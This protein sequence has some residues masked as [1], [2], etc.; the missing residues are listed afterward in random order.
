MT[1]RDATERRCGL[2]GLAE[3]GN[4]LINVVWALMFINAPIFLRLARG[5]VLTVREQRYV[6]AAHALGNSRARIMVR[7]ILPNITGQAVVQVGIQRRSI[8]HAIEATTTKAAATINRLW[9]F[10]TK[11]TFDSTLMP[12]AATIPNITIPAP[13]STNAG[14]DATTCA[15]FGNRPNKSMARTPKCAMLGTE[16][17]KRFTIN[18][19]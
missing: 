18:R 11:S 10:L 17:M 2:I 5:Q 16:T 1:S 9:W 3:A 13:P 15:I 7:H 12:F 8:P 6:E 4:D 14:T 19:R